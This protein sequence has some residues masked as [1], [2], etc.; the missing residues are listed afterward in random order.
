MKKSL[1]GYTGFV[2]SNLC[3]KEKFDGQYNSKNIKEAYGTNPDLLIYSGVPAQK[4][5]ANQ[6]P[7]KDFTIIENA[8]ENIKKI[9]PKKIVLIS[10]IDVYKEPI[11]VDE[12]S[13]IVLDNLQPYG[14]NRYYLEKWIKDNFDDYLIVHLPGL[15]GK[16]IK[17][18][19]IYDLINIIPSMLTKEKFIELAKEDNFIEKYYELQGNGFYKCIENL[20]HDE[21]NKLKNYFKKIGFSALNFTDS[22]ASYQFYNLSYLWEHINKA[23]ENNIRVLNLAVEPVTAKELYEYILKEEFHNEILNDNS[24]PKYDFKTK[25]TS[26]FDGEDGYIYKKEFVLEDIKKFIESIDKE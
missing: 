6:F 3:L 23:L 20:S 25:Y 10:T 13:E 15:Y 1:V 17:K 21:K 22:R 7:E 5:I 18:N 12:D 8:I 19:F 14:K 11:N 16:N 4:F 26:L 24:I 2:G 9:N